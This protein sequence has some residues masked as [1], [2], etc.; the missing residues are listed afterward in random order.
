M[1]SWIL[2]P[3]GTKGREEG[4]WSDTFGLRCA[5]EWLLTLGMFL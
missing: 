4:A 5:I 1:C 2:V 3:E